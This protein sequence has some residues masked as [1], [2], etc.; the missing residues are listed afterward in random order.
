MGLPGIGGNELICQA[1]DLYPPLQYLI[2]TGSSGYV[3]PEE[4]KN[5]GITENDIF[6]KPVSDMSVFVKAIRSKTDGW[7]IQGD[8]ITR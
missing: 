5:M 4:L 3:L 6:K 1:H 7:Y 8:F 2:H